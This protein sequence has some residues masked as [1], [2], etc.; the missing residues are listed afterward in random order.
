MGL[1][2][3]IHWIFVKFE[4]DLSYRKII[5]IWA[6]SMQQPIEFRIVLPI[7]YFRH[8]SFLSS[9]CME[10]SLLTHLKLSRWTD[11]HKNDPILMRPS[12]F[13]GGV[14]MSETFNFPHWGDQME[15]WPFTMTGDHTLLPFWGFVR[16]PQ[17]RL[18]FLSIAL[19]NIVFPPT[20][21]PEITSDIVVVGA[22]SGPLTGSHYWESL[23]RQ[24]RKNQ[25]RM[26]I[27]FSGTTSS[28][29]GY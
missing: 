16:N 9:K 8:F 11:P 25:N 4:R 10:L 5:K 23:T 7:S 14:V 6:T 15:S 2:H 27:A 18:V 12:R 21:G 1:Y 19:Y 26:A 24:S 29:C 28:C 20:S 13:A 17:N 3:H 22:M